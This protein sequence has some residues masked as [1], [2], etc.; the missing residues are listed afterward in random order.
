MKP[1][2]LVCVFPRSL[3]PAPSVCVFAAVRRLASVTIDS[4][5]QMTYWLLES[6]SAWR[7]CTCPTWFPVLWKVR[8]FLCPL[9]KI[10]DYFNF[11][12]NGPF[13]LWQIG[14]KVHAFSPIL[15]S[16]PLLGPNPCLICLRSYFQK[17]ALPSHC[18]TCSEYVSWTK[19]PSFGHSRKPGCGVE[20]HNISRFIHFP[21]PG[22]K[23]P[24]E[25]AN[26]R[27]IDCENPKIPHAFATRSGRKSLESCLMPQW[28]KVHTTLCTG[29]NQD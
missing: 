13:L 28:E 7:M 23:C 19:E 5:W 15:D 27:F 29:F 18:G 21:Y 10:Q 3:P 9:M 2:R 26:S 12:R 14:I 11:H 1:N 8:F 24:S 16:L 22:S 25:N 20:T 17:L 4:T 6:V